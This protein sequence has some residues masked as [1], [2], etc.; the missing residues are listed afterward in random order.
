MAKYFTPDYTFIQTKNLLLSGL[1]L[2]GQIESSK[3]YLLKYYNKRLIRTQTIF[4]L[5]RYNTQTLLSVIELISDKE[6][7][8]IFKV[9]QSYILET[10]RLTSSTFIFM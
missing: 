8:N 1:C 7:E 4:T 5:P 9:V 3:H 10:W 6:I 2:C